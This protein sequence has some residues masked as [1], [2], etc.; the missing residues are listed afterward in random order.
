MPLGETTPPKLNDKTTLPSQ[1]PDFAR[2]LIY[3]DTLPL[4]DGSRPIRHII[5]AWELKALNSGCVWWSAESRLAA[6]RAVPTYLGQCQDQAEAGFAH[7]SDWTHIYMLLIVGPYF[8]Q[9]VWRARPPAEILTSVEVPDPAELEPRGDYRE[10][11]A[12][13]LEVIKHYE[14]RN[15]PEVLWYNAP[16]FTYHLEDPGSES[17]QPASLSPEFLWA[18][19][20]PLIH[21]FPDIP[22][23]PTS[24]FY[25]ETTTRPLVPMGDKVS[26]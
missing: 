8:T 12:Q 11:I 23:E 3:S 4:P 15:V 18:L 19:A 5:D 14:K 25:P 9:L 6:L 2:T 16:V 22:V 17:Y 10:L 21:H 13:L 1:F 7:N 24:W 26:F 20:E